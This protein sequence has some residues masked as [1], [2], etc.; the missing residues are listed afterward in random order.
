MHRPKSIHRSSVQLQYTGRGGSADGRRQSG[1]ANSLRLMEVLC[2]RHHNVIADEL[3]ADEKAESLLDIYR[4]CLVVHKAMSSVQSQ[5][6]PR[7]PR[8]RSHDGRQGERCHRL[9]VA[10]ERRSEPDPR[11]PLSDPRSYAQSL[12]MYTPITNTYTTTHVLSNSL[13]AQFATRT[14]AV[15]STRAIIIEVS[16]RLPAVSASSLPYQTINRWSYCALPSPQLDLPIG[17][18]FATTPTHPMSR[19]CTHTLLATCYALSDPLESRP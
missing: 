16:S 6:F 19:D 7:V 8:C 10:V 1:V 12:Y 14:T 3:Q 17:A 11:I 2:R 4:D 15:P 9:H 13:C 5:P 18:F